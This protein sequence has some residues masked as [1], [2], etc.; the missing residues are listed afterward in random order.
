MTNPVHVKVAVTSNNLTDVDADFANTRQILI[1]DVRAS[2]S[3]FLD[4]LQFDGRTG[5]VRGPGGGKGCSGDEPLD[6]GSAEGLESRIKS[7]AGCGIL[8]TRRLTDFAAVPIFNGGT[9]PVKLERQREIATVLN[10]LQALIRAKTPGWLRKKL[11][12]DEAEVAPLL[13]AG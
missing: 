3:T 6:G 1:Y 9:F 4:A 12:V 10:Q 13:A 8:F 11:V 2:G 7:L 5:E